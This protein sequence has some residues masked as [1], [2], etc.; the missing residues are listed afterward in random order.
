[1]SAQPLVSVMTPVYN[2]EKYLRECIESVLAQTYDHW[3]YIIVNNCSTDQTLEIAKSY[4]E[5][6]PRIRIHNN[7]EFVGLIRNHN[8]GLRQLSPDSKYCKILHADDWLFPECLMRM[9][10]VA[11]AHP[12]A[13]IVGAYRLAG[14]KVDLTGLP[15]STSIISGKELCRLKLLDRLHVFG[16]PTSI[17]LRGEIIRSKES[18]YNEPD[19]SADQEACFE[20]LQNWDFGFVHQVL[21][22]TRRHDESATELF[23]K[24][25]NTILLSRFKNYIKYGPI[26]LKSK[27]YEQHLEWW[28]D[29]YYNFLAKIILF[30]GGNK[31][32]TYHQQELEK[33]GYSIRL[34]ELMKAIA[35]QCAFSPKATLQG[36]V[37][38]VAKPKEVLS[39]L[40]VETD[41]S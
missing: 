7:Q 28:L 32:W 13:G 34:P 2:G 31:I 8:I 38:R 16:T 6:E 21:T 41:Y 1:M 15:Y 35:L 5:R 20:V 19:L 39:N 40:D 14:T 25:L 27:E 11:E 37:E 3:E 12:T 18:F 26:Y 24:K 4:A 29:Y 10:A 17:L 36:I 30:G 33:L 23:A 22:Y 9:V